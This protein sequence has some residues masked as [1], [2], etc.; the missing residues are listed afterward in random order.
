MSLI[1]LSNCQKNCSTAT[2]FC[3][4]ETPTTYLVRHLCKHQ[5]QQP[6][7]ELVLYPRTLFYTCCEQAQFAHRRYMIYF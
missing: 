7:L 1:R 3:L 5:L 2:A 6:F 4:Y